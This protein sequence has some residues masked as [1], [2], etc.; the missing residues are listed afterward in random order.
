MTND[1]PVLY[2]ASGKVS[3]GQTY[4]FEVWTNKPDERVWVLRQKVGPQTKE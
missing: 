2:D 1:L 4:Q 3:F